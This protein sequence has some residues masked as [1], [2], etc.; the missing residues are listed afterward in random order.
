MK[1]ST[2][3]DILIVGAFAGVAF[4]ISRYYKHKKQRERE[5]RETLHF[6]LF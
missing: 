1:S 2:F 5:L 4:Y 6:Q 3:K